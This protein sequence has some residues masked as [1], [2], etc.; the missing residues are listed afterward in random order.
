MSVDF[1]KLNKPGLGSG[2]FGIKQKNT[3]VSAQAAKN[4][5]SSSA[6]TKKSIFSNTRSPNFVAGQNVA[7]QLG[8]YSYQNARARANM[9]F[10]PRHAGP[11]GGVSKAI[12]RFEMPGPSTMEKI[13][14]T[15]QQAVM[16]GQTVQ[17]LAGT[18]SAIGGIF[19]GSSTSALTAGVEGLTGGAASSASLGLGTETTSLMRASSFSSIKGLEDKVNANKLNFA[20]N[21]AS[22][23]ANMKSEVTTILGEANA[24]EGLKLAG[25]GNLDTSALDVST[26]ADM[27]DLNSAMDTIDRDISKMR[28]FYTT[29]LD[30]AK[31]KVSSK[32]GEISGTLDA[33]SGELERLQAKKTAG[34]I[35]AEE[36]ARIESLKNEI[37]TLKEQKA[38][39]EEAEKAIEQAVSK[40][41]TNIDKL[42]DKK[43]QLRDIQQFEG[44]VKDKKYDLAKSQDKQ[45]NDLM[46][47]IDKYIKKGNSEAEIKEIKSQLAKLAADAQSA[48]T[49]I[50]NSKNQSYTNLA[51]TLT[52]ATQSPYV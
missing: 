47:Q 19:S 18:V 34:T 33:K 32:K 23:G 52:K 29:D 42:N 1:A 51:Q 44:A 13:T 48:G 8:R 24:A 41:Q 43:A 2:S 12:P 9:P 4:L 27:S 28:N 15:M 17:G 30:G 10:V 14:Q 25:A 11:S 49:P 37:T 5:A 35:T 36:E 26:I 31:T 6:A 21:Y 20:S 22:E 3:S 50:M 16:L 38:Q 46:K 39:L 45:M 7:K 40:C